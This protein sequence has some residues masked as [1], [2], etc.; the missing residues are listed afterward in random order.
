MTERLLIISV[1][2]YPLYAHYI[3]K[4]KIVSNLA[5]DKILFEV[6]H[7]AYSGET[8]LEK[9]LEYGQEEMKKIIRPGSW[10]L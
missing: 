7:K 9:A 4:G 8:T 2:S 6:V 3:N 10:K 5:I 1:R